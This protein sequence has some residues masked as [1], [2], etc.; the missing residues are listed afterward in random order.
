MKEN[1]GGANLP[2]FLSAKNYSPFISSELELAPKSPILYKTNAVATSEGAVGVCNF[3]L[4]LIAASLA[5]SSPR[6][7]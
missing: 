4:P 7:L 2:S 6:R 1:E 3:P 5:G